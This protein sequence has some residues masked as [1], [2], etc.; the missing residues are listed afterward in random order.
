MPDTS[1]T[2]APVAVPA[3]AATPARVAVP[4]ASASSPAAAV[5]QIET[6]AKAAALG[7]AHTAR[8]SLRGEI[9]GHPLSTVII[10]FASG[11]LVT[12]LAALL[13]HFGA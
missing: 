7:A 2:G 12:A 8:L 10:A 5:D 1:T 9:A 13:I 4:A 6:V 11:V 3:P